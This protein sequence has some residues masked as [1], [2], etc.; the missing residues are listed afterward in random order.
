MSQR[1]RCFGLAEK[2]FQYASPE[3]VGISSEAV[4]RLIDTMCLN[5]KDQETHSFMIIRHKKIIAEGG[6]DKKSKGKKATTAKKTTATKKTGSAASNRSS[7]SK[8][9]KSS[10]AKK[11]SAKKASSDKS[12]S[13]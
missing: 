7:S 2:W 11:T 6:K 4:E 3:S 1:L 9:K 12:A 10:T 13:K 8:T 5:E